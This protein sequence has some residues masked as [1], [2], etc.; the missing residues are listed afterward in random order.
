MFLDAFRPDYLRHTSY[1]KSLSKENVHGELETILGYTGIIATFLTGLYPDKHG[2]VTLFNKS[3][4]PKRRVNNIFLENIK[5]YLKNER[6]F[7]SPLK[8]P[9]HKSRHFETALKKT[10]PQRGCLNKPT[11]FDILEKNDL[12]FTT[13]DWPNIYNNRRG[14]IFTTNSTESVINKVKASKSDFVFAHFLAL[15]DAHKTGV[16][17][18]KIKDMVRELDEAIECLDRERILFFSDHGMYDIKSEMN[19][20]LA[21]SE[22]K[23][24]FGKDYVYFIGSTMARFWFNNKSAN[25]SVEHLLE[26]LGGG[27]IID[28]SEFN[29]PQLCDITYLADLGTVFH[30][31][32]F[33]GDARYKSMHGWDPREKEQKAFYLVKSIGNEK[34][35]KM[36]DML[37]TLLDYM[38]LSKVKCDGESVI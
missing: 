2:I 31:N 35:A 25:K 29:L 21:L 23:L 32:F 30:P 20:E 15:E 37:P 14:K 9:Q 7:Y 36:I 22:L 12:S 10:W 16:K 6:F 4:V 26:S 28:Y 8:I 19:L 3:D 13:I 34:S 24:R 18:S 17:S 33:M 1:L 27:R 38:K 11:F 5:R